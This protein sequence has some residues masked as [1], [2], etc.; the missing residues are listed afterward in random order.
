MIFKTSA[1]AF[2][3]DQGWQ[4]NNN[5]WKKTLGAHT[6]TVDT[7][8]NT[9]EIDRWHYPIYTSTNSFSSFPF[10]N[11][12]LVPYDHAVTNG[13]II[14]NPDST[15]HLQKKLITCDAFCEHV[16]ESVY[17][18]LKGGRYIIGDSKGLD[19]TTIISILDYFN[20][21]YQS[22]CYDKRQ[23]NVDSFY[24]QLQ[25]QHWG[26]NQTAYFTQPTKLITGMYGDEY[27]LRNPL[28]V[29]WLLTD[30]NLLDVFEQ[31]QNTYMYDYVTKYYA[32]KLKNLS[33]NPDFLQ[34]ILNDYQLWS[35]NYTEVICPFKNI[36]IL[37]LGLNLD[38]DTI[39]KQVTDGYINKKIISMCNKNLLPNLDTKKNHSDIIF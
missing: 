11:Y 15:I 17:S 2:E 37:L 13:K 3:H 24:L 27:M 12:K 33:L 16:I 21:E 19:C 35:H 34:T 31:S 9:I 39:I 6:T 22:F 20:I 25:Q 7:K 23:T 38:I 29:Q 10:E 28:Y 30:T 26:F 18:Q 1:T 5:I 4:S 36:D 14:H 8:T 32:K